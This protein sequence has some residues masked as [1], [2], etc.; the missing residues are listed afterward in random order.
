MLSGSND[1]TLKCFQL[2]D[3]RF[4]FALKGHH[5]WVNSAQFSPDTRLIASG[6]EDKT[7]KLFDITSHNEIKT[8][9]PQHLAAVNDVQFHP[10][11]TCIAAG[12]FDQS[13]NIWDIR[14]SKQI[15]HYD[16]H[17]ASVQSLT[18]HPNGRYL[19]SSSVDST[20]KIW[21]LR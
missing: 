4:M 7:V 8:F 14:S 3:R 2:R 17:N 15:Q 6:S 19:V 20:V 18:F 1:M 9:E 10:D 16:A 12:S 5:N 11:G 21:D 13:I